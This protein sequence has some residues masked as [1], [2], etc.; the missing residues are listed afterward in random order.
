[1][2]VM[3]ETTTDEMDTTKSPAAALVT[4]NDRAYVCHTCSTEKPVYDAGRQRAFDWSSSVTFDGQFLDIDRLQ[5]DVSQVMAVLDDNITAYKRWLK[6]KQE[7]FEQ[8]FTEYAASEELFNQLN[9]IVAQIK[10]GQ[11]MLTSWYMDVREIVSD[12]WDGIRTYATAKNMLLSHG[13]LYEQSYSTGLSVNPVTMAKKNRTKSKVLNKQKTKALSAETSIR[14]SLFQLESELNAFNQGVIRTQNGKFV[15]LAD[16]GEAIDSLYN[17][18]SPLVR[19]QHELANMINRTKVKVKLRA[20]SMPD[21]G[22]ASKRD[23]FVQRLKPTVA[24]NEFDIIKTLQKIADTSLYTANTKAGIDKAIAFAEKNIQTEFNKTLLDELTREI[25]GNSSVA[26]FDRLRLSMRRKADLFEN[27]AYIKRLSKH[28]HA[29]DR[30]LLGTQLD[31]LLAETMQTIG[32]EYDKRQNATDTG[33]GDVNGSG[34]GAGGSG[35]TA[36]VS[37]GVYRFTGFI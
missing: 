28:L 10:Q 1:M 7:S 17:R 8:Y 31:E 25:R 16:L 13:M 21:V 4:T 35:A 2:V 12:I 32:G 24:P 9:L 11:K 33:R 20:G 23:T 3:V 27:V 19:V 34:D 26:V 6:E 37:D 15:N 18:E 22:E 36:G 14:Q 29:E 5:A 30:R